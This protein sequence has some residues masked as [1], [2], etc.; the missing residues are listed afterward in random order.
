MKIKKI[1]KEIQQNT[2]RT[3]DDLLNILEKH[4]DPENE[5]SENDETVFMIYLIA[6]AIGYSGAIEYADD[7]LEISSLRYDDDR[8]SQTT[9][10]FDASKILI[11]GEY[12]I[13]KNT[14][15][16]IKILGNLKINYPF[17]IIK[18]Q[19]IHLYSVVDNEIR[20]KIET[21]FDIDF[22]E[23]KEIK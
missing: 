5:N 3:E 9:A 21:I 7:L 17:D 23:K 4:S 16:G 22:L 10:H 13:D 11:L 1:L 14:K 20:K 18:D 8:F 2:K 12:G 6:D 15:E 19:I